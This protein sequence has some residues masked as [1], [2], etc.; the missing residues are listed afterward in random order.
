MQLGA[1]VEVSVVRGKVQSAEV[2]LRYDADDLPARVSADHVFLAHHVEE[3]DVW[4]PVPAGAAPGGEGVVTGTTTYSSS[5]RY[6]TPR[7]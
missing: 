4:M 6:S 5:P 3:L 7:T 2:R 1:D